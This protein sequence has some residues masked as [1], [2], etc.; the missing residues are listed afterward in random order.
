MFFGQYT[1]INFFNALSSASNQEVNAASLIFI[2]NRYE[3]EISFRI[4]RDVLR[5]D[6]A[7]FL[8][9]NFPKIQTNDD[10]QKSTFSDIASEYL[11]KYADPNVG[12]LEED[13]DDATFE[14]YIII[15]DQGL[16]LADLLQ[17]FRK[18]KQEEFASYLFNI[19]NVL[20]NR[21]QWD[22]DPYAL[23]LKI[24]YENAKALSKSLKKLSTYMKKTIETLMQKCTLEELT[25]FLINEQSG[26]FVKEYSRLIK[27]QN[28]HVYRRHILQMLDHMFMD[29]ELL[30]LIVLGYACEE[31][32][33]EEAAKDKIDEIYYSISSFFKTDCT[34]IMQDIRQKSTM[35]IQI[36][37]AKLRLSQDV[38]ETS[39]RCVG[40]LT[41]YLMS[42]E[43][44]D[45]DAPE[46]IKNCCRM[47]NSWQISLNSAKAPV[48]K[49]RVVE[50]VPEEVEL[51][52]ENDVFQ[53][54][55]R[56]SEAM[57]N[58]YSKEKCKA[59]L[60]AAMHGR[61]SMEAKDFMFNEKNDMLFVIYALIYAEE[62]GY[63]VCDQDGYFET[64]HIKI[65][66]F[67]IRERDNHDF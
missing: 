9:E 51:L 40:Q 6:Y 67:L 33:D 13:R 35:Y 41:K 24:V 12:W 63:E 28:I 17:K 59:Y 54:R 58:A 5:D 42:L 10:G 37:L 19:F 1:P 45:T 23:G 50:E 27:S 14:R 66:N 34:R 38:T 52:T 56:L 4:K 20:N 57:D 22:S 11:R 47:Q 46:E 53:E 15:T 44:W 7:V 2:A 16:Q 30:D 43:N 65:R 48:V 39:I 61:H 8:K 60:E 31:D 64:E 21:V 49:R 29:Q 18:P 25:T 62:L 3:D 55:I 32:V 36:A 26:D